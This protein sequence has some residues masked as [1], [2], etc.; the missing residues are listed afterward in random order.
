[1]P[2]I[3]SN[4]GHNATSRSKHAIS[5]RKCRAKPQMP[6]QYANARNL[7]TMAINP[8]SATALH[9]G[10]CLK[11]QHAAPLAAQSCG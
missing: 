10:N 6:G 1:V 8:A 3:S 4:A 5:Y 11:N 9:E 7:P 2:F